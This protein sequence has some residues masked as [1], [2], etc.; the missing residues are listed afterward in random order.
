[1]YK[2]SS[3]AGHSQIESWRTRTLMSEM[4][5]SPQ[6]DVDWKHSSSSIDAL[7]FLQSLGTASRPIHDLRSRLEL[8]RD[9]KADR[10][11]GTV[12]AKLLGFSLRGSRLEPRDDVTSRRTIEHLN[13]QHRLLFRRIKEFKG[14]YKSMTPFHVDGVLGRKTEVAVHLDLGLVF[15]VVRGRAGSVHS[16][17]LYSFHMPLPLLKLHSQVYVR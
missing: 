8:L 6:V 9:L 16:V 17:L 1:M 15:S 3:N 10:H 4:S 5:S 7:H 14:S 12:P 2:N 11:D 13:Q